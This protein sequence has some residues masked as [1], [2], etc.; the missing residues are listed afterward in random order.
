MTF[1]PSTIEGGSAIVAHFGAWPS[2]HDAEVVSVHLQRSSACSL[3]I[4]AFNTTST[5]DEAGHYITQ[6]HGIVTFGFEQIRELQLN[7][8]NEQNV[9]FGLEISRESDGAIRLD[10]EGCYGL[11]GSVIANVVR[12]SVKPGTPP[13]S[14]YAK[15]EN[16]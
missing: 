9:I 12:V 7:S 13:D 8:F 5:V 16:Q 2:F 4:H 11:E 3:S 15:S 10:I 14:I 1:D 6:D